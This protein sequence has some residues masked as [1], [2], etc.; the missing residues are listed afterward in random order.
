MLECRRNYLNHAAQP[1]TI[2]PVAR[3]PPVEIDVRNLF[4]R[5]DA[6]KTLR[7]AG[8]MS[9]TSADGVDVA[10][11]E[12]GPRGVE[13]LAFHTFPYTAAV[14]RQLFRLFQPQTARVDDICHMNFLIGELFADAVS[15]LAR[16][17]RI[18]LSSLDLI[19]SH[20][21]TIYHIPKG[22]VAG[23]RRIRSTLQIGE[24]S[25]IAERTGVTTVADFRPRDVAAGGEG[26]PLVPYTD[27]VLFHDRRRNRAIQNIGGIA[28][29][30][31]L[32]RRGRPK[33]VLAFD[34]GPGNMM[35]DRVVSRLTAGRQA[36]DKGG[37]LAAQGRVQQRLLREL[38]RHP[39]LRRRPPKST[40][41]ELFGNAFTDA[42]WQRTT[43]AGMDPRDLLATVTA[44][45]AA[46]MADAYRRF[47]PG[48]LDEV[49]LCG[50]GAWNDTLVR[51][52]SERVAP[53]HV[54]RMEQYGL[55]VD[56]KEAVSFAILAYATVRGIPA[57][58]PAATGARKAV[59]LGK[60][61]PGRTH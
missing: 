9:G 15:A 22:R 14:R 6:K 40:G 31:W 4:A 60:I 28:N 58:V 46:T 16:R 24:P 36:Y 35:M 3:G 26:A 38:M 10:F 23:A 17:R 47:L 21:Q 13:L 19:G 32:P 11:T 43:G 49:I 59:V 7:V 30:T 56:A 54:V 61:I 8:L 34:T 50:G 48:P 29:V 20:G 57:N 25:V 39:F 53:A 51:M 45:T 44:F 42:L 41:R 2:S 18:P 55:S 27:Y 12:I 52:L 1:A 33:D 37:R 5:L